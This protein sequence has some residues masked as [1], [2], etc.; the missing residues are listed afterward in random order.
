MLLYK[1]QIVRCLQSYVNA[2]VNFAKCRR[3][4]CVSNLL[5]FCV[6]HLI[7]IFS[8]FFHLHDWLSIYWVTCFTLVPA[9]FLS[10][11][12][13]ICSVLHV[14]AIS[15]LI[16]AILPTHQPTYHFCP[17]IFSFYDLIAA[18]ANYLTAICVH[19]LPTICSNH[20]LVIYVH[21]QQRCLKIKCLP[22]TLVTKKS[23]MLHKVYRIELCIKR[24]Y[25]FLAV[26]LLFMTVENIY[27]LPNIFSFLSCR[28][29]RV[30]I[31]SLSKRR[32]VQEWSE[33]LHMFLY[34]RVPGQW[35]CNR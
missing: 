30:Q 23:S 24:F 22:V 13:S 21:N 10:L 34:A 3:P 5:A 17:Q 29:W 15:V 19:H 4:F 11:L 6:Q 26:P 27:C 14:F 20:V 12:S 18:C 32:Y 9:T 7:S 8:I 28:Y 31:K 2:M 25:S 16:F 35:L 33:Q 1:F